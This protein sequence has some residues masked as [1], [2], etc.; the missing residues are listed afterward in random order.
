VH[1]L[2]SAQEYEKSL[3]T[4]CWEKPE[5]GDFKSCVQYAQAVSGSSQW[6]LLSYWKSF[7][8]WLVA[9]I[10]GFYGCCRAIVAVCI[11]VWRGFRRDSLDP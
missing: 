1:Q 8:F 9:A 3:F 11:W 6:V 4:D 5:H 10:L 7:W 2:H